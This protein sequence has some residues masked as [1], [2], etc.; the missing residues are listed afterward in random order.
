[1]KDTSI[2]IFDRGEAKFQVML[3]RLSS[4]QGSGFAQLNQ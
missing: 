3:G 4:E 1:M 2:F